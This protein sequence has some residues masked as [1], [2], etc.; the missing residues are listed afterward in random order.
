M[1][2]SVGS[3][4]TGA[5]SEGDRDKRRHQRTLFDGIA[6][7]YEESRPAYPA[8]VEEFVTATAALAPGAA[9]LEIGCGTGQL[10]E[11]L[12]GHGFRVTAIDIG[13]SMVAAAR[14]R[15]TGAGVWFQVTAFEDLDAAGGSFDLVISSAAFHWIDPEIAFGKSARLLRPGGWLGLL[16]TEE[17]YDHPVGTALDDLWIRHGDTGGAWERRPSDPD[18]IAATGLFGAPACLAD[19]QRAILTAGELIGLEST[20]ATFLSWSP[21]T[22]RHF[23]DELRRTLERHPVVHLTRHTSVTMAQVAEATAGGSGSAGT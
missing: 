4:I 15:L 5:E 3:V 7:R 9:V 23:T 14:R 22:Q 19:S 12:A 10:T 17:R 18:A 1:P 8:R 13:P 2:Y 16:G 11:R 6:E 20:R 21:G